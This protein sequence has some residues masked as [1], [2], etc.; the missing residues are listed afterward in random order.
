MEVNSHPMEYLHRASPPPASSAQEPEG[1]KQTAPGS[2]MIRNRLPPGYRSTSR[3]VRYR[4]RTRL[5]VEEKPEAGRTTGE[6]AYIDRTR[7]MPDGHRDIVWYFVCIHDCRNQTA[8]GR[9]P[10][11]RMQRAKT[12]TRG[13]LCGQR[14]RLIMEM[15]Y[16]A[17]YEYLT[18][19]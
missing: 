16:E 1:E 15:T 17:C 6:G 11:H 5:T 7:R 10:H 14:H 13:S 9:Y 18:R 19:K 8:S 3:R 12:T 2:I 4:M